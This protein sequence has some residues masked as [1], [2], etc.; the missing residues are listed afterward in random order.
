VKL[1]KFIKYITMETNN[2][3]D[4]GNTPEKGSYERSAQL[5]T[6]NDNERVFT[7]QSGE[8]D[9]DNPER[10]EEY[11]QGLSGQEIDTGQAEREEELNAS[12]QQQQPGTPSAGSGNLDINNGDRNSGFSREGENE[13]R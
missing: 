1:K 11:G 3:Q 9:N 12:P 2:S 7:G 10:T 4:S 5:G 6:S 8:D 13:S